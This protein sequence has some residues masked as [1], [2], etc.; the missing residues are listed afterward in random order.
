MIDLQ[1][2]IRFGGEDLTQGR[3]A[4]RCRA[5]IGRRFVFSRRPPFRRVS[6][7][8]KHPISPVPRRISPKVII[9]KGYLPCLLDFVNARLTCEFERLS[10]KCSRAARWR[11]SPDE[12]TKCKLRCTRD[13]GR[14]YHQH[15]TNRGLR[16][17]LP[18]LAFNA[19][20]TSAFNASSFNMVTVACISSGHIG[21][22]P[23]SQ[24]IQA[25]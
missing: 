16:P 15:E 14:K 18:R 3:G 6:A 7:R 11:L 1:G 17:C 2:K 24:L 13:Y 19:V 10:Y 9:T 20:L 22:S 4:C 25:L 8:P 5:T 23:S 21:L 12:R